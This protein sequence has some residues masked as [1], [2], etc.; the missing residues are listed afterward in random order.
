ML[1][2]ALLVSMIALAGPVAAQ[3]TAA[4][5]A[6]PKLKERV[7]VTGDLVRI[8]DLIDNAGAVADIAVFRSPD[9]GST[10]GL[11]VSQLLKVISRYRIAG[12]D[13]KGLSE[14]VVTRPSRAITAKEIEARIAA[15]LAGQHGF[16]DPNNIAITFDRDV[17][18]IH[19]ESTATAELQVA[20]LIF[21]P[22]TGRFS[23]SLDLPGSAVARRL[24][25]RFSGTATA[26]LEATVLVRTLS[27]GDVIKQS[28]IAVERRPKQEVTGEIVSKEAAI[29]L[30]VKRPLA[31]GA[32]LRRADLMK[33][34]LIQRN[35]PVTVVFEVPGVLLTARGKALEAGAAGDIIA[36]LNIQSNRTVQATVIGPG[37]VAVGTGARPPSPLSGSTSS[38]ALSTVE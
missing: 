13:T 34:E 20:R 1:R 6:G 25:L 38:S 3:V 11:P 10:G 29:G 7:V 5:P 37:R 19:V 23:V 2:T 31:A 12:L 36:V 8:G 26:M 27:R 24:P 22:R 15:A 35:E 16:D 28:D 30:A 9:L 33:P 17:R 14:V 32:V 18:T 21:E 4:L